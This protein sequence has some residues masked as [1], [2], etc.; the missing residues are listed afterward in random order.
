MAWTHLI[1]LA[2]AGAC[3]TLARYGLGGLIQRL[4]GEGFPAGTFAVNALGSLLFGLVW[5]ATAERGLLPETARL[6][7]LTGFMG[8]FTTFSTF[9]FETGQ[10]MREAQW[11]LA[12]A[13]LLGQAT[14]GIACLLL[15]LA[16]GRWI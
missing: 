15:G 8:A 10:L 2:V 16:A 13:N 4:A 12:G 14:V 5:A 11:L 6:A 1:W 7:V 9:M 3:G